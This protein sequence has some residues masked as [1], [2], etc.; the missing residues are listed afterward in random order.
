ME[1]LFNL[2]Y[3]ELVWRYCS[4]K[5]MHFV[6]PLRAVEFV[7]F[8]CTKYVYCWLLLQSKFEFQLR[9]QEFIEL[10]RAENLMRALSYARKY[11]APWG[12]TH[13]KELQRVLAILAF[14]SSTECAQYKVKYFPASLDSWNFQSCEFF[15]GIVFVTIYW[16]LLTWKRKEP[17][18]NK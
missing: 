7:V 9:L 16:M 10:V 5:R 13:M 15:W 3:Y 18:E 12:A 4:T 14:K 8:T 1:Y 11:L 17:M 2:T 6:I